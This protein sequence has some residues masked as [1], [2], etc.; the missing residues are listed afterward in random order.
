MPHPCLD[1]AVCY[2]N[3]RVDEF[4][5]E[6]LGVTLPKQKT[7]GLVTAAEWLLDKKH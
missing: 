7:E 3:I 6:H 5:M 4:A 1:T 2:I